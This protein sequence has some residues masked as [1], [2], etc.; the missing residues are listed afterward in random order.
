MCAAAAQ[1]KI[2]L[3]TSP[4]RRLPANQ[5]ARTWRSDHHTCSKTTHHYPHTSLLALLLP[6]V[7]VPIGRINPDFEEIRL[8][9]GMRPIAC[10][11]EDSHGIGEVGRG[12]G[13][14]EDREGEEAANVM[15]EAIAI[16]RHGR[17][18]GPFPAAHPQEAIL[19]SVQGLA[20]W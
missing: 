15:D 16:Q 2:P 11:C 9:W 20:A 7:L 18:H 12:E 14:K 5:A 4:R 1:P 19:S 17:F 8:K 6:I 10:V 13:R 3:P